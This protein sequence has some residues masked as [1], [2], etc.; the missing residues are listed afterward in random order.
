MEKLLFTDILKRLKSVDFPKVDVVVGIATGGLVPAALVAS[1]LNVELH[2]IHLNFRNEDNKPQHDK[3]LII[4][5]LNLSLPL[6]Y[7]ILLVD[8]V[9]VSG[10]TLEV[11]EQFLKSYHVTSFVLKGK[12][13]IVLYP[14]IKDC[15]KWPWT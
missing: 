2:T 15:V 6:H 1:L 14:E 3:P 12:G 9:S 8:D 7:K 11:A 5:D 13:D 4:K 10:Q